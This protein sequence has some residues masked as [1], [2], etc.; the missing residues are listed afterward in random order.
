MFSTARLRLSGWYL[1]ILTL[2]IALLSAPLYY[3]LLVAQRTELK[4]LHSGLG[5]AID[6]VFADDE[7]T[8]AVQI[9]ILSVATLLVA[10]IGAFVLAGR[11]LQ[12]IEEVMDRQR[13]FAAAASHELRTPLTVLQVSLEV[14][15]L[16]RRT[17]EEYEQTIRGAIQEIVHMGQLAKDLLILARNETE[18]GTLALLPLCLD[19]VARAAVERA[20]PLSRQKGQTVEVMVSDRLPIQGDELKLRQALLN[21]VENAVIYTPKGGSICVM[22]RRER[23]RAVLEVRD[24]GPG[25]AAEHLCHLFEPFY[26]VNSARSDSGHA[27]LGLALAAWIVRAH[28]GHIEAASQVGS[29][30][31]FRLS[32]PCTS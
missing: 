2:I 22:G 20:E 17:P 32:L 23:G 21:I 30:T 25:V 12:P 24:T 10:A 28:G 19:D 13:R 27:G 29:G 5:H 14:A 3:L 16:K 9:V 31:V 18:A 1:L 7:G 8:L 4:S 26:Q 11:T 6:L 15:L